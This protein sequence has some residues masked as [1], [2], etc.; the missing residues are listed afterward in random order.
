MP[1]GGG[2]AKKS[3]V[4]SLTSKPR[5]GLAV[6]AGGTLFFGGLCLIALF[7]VPGLAGVAVPLAALYLIIGLGAWQEIKA[8]AVAGM[9]AFGIFCLLRMGTLVTNFA[10]GKLGSTIVFGWMTW[11]YWDAL[12]HWGEES[13]DVEDG[14]EEDKPIISIVLLLKA[15]RY[16]E[17]FILTQVLEEAWGGDFSSDD[18]EN[19]DGFVVGE[20]PMFVV[21]SPHGMFMIHNRPEPYF[22]DAEAVGEEIG[23]LRL[24]R[25]V[26]EHQAWLSV[27]LLSAFDDSQPPEMFYPLIIRLIYELAEAGDVLAVLRPETG[28]IN[29]WSDDVLEAL[30]RPDGLEAFN[31]IDA[32][33]PVIPV[34]EDDPAMVAA[35]GEARRRWPEFLEQFQSRSDD[36][37]FG[38]KAPVTSGGNTE[39][40]W[41]EVSGL[42]P[43]YI[44]GKL[45]NEPVALDG[46][47]L[48]S[49]VEVPV[50]ELNDWYFTR[51]E[52]DPV[53]LFTVKAVQEAQN[54]FRSAQDSE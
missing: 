4:K 1:L 32:E 49:V 12:K 6:P 2:I 8:F 25:A 24:R 7:V 47:S 3:D 39:F 33:V 10:W 18:E 23:E 46:L 20:T 9:I 53:G 50:A 16:L 45:G 14:D 15:P 36:D 29:L 28:Q 52:G 35:V 17:D 42:E 40:I 37:H 51:G 26:M 11:E 43:E 27:D 21:K 19:Q 30:L 54:R 38:V 31:R 5:Y 44:H 13:P 41:I 48:G 34:A 22:E